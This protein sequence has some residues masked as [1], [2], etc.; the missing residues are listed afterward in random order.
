MH[1]DKMITVIF[2]VVVRYFYYV[3]ELQLVQT[4]VMA[5]KGIKTVGTDKW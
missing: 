1:T 5:T 4:F 2:F 3:P